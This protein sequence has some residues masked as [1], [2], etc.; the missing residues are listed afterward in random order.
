MAP[1][2]KRWMAYGIVAVAVILIVAGIAHDDVRHV[3]TNAYLIC[4]SCIGIK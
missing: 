4:Y 1:R 2:A 3:I